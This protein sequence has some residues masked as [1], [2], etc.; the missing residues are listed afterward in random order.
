MAP[1]TIAS[2]ISAKPAAQKIEGVLITNKGDH[3]LVL[4][5]KNVRLS[6]AYE[7]ADLV[8][9]EGVVPNSYKGQMLRRAAAAALTQMSAAAQQQGVSLVIVSAY[10]SFW[11]QQATFASWAARSGVASA[12]TFSA[13]PGHSQHQLG[14]AVDFGVFGSKGFSSIFENTPAGTWLA[15]NSYKYGFVLGYPKGAQEI[16]GYIYEPWHYR[17]IGVENASH[18]HSIG[19]ILEEYLQRFGVW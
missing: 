12:E 13:R 15:E 4:I 19:M 7:P 14:T 16:T 10:R 18:M 17:Y 6:E 2:T 8:S 5:N 11:S 1:T 9:L 3:L